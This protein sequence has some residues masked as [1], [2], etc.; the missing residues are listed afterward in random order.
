MPLNGP[1]VVFN[2]LIELLNLSERLSRL[3]VL[4]YIGTYRTLTA[5]LSIVGWSYRPLIYVA[6]VQQSRLT[7]P[8]PRGK[9]HPMHYKDNISYARSCI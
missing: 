2:H 5:F 1:T 6:G 4:P 3:E 9:T 8:F 7:D